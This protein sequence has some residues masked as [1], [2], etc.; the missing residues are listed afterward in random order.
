LRKLLLIQ[1]N[2][3][4][5]EADILA[6]LVEQEKQF[7]HSKQVLPAK[8]SPVKI[9]NLANLRR[10]RNGGTNNQ[11]LLKSKNAKEDDRK[12]TE[13]EILKETEKDTNEPTKIESLNSTSK[14]L[15]FNLNQPTQ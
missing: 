8:Q 11:Q 13:L 14:N 1:E 9:N 15:A 6:G 3:G 12:A 2:H 4:V 7:I 10:N 5:F